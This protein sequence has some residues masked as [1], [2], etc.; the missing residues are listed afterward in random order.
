MKD[1]QPE[2]D[3]H[4]YGTASDEK[5]IGQLQLQSPTSSSIGGDH[6]TPPRQIAGISD[7]S[8]EAVEITPTAAPQGEPQSARQRENIGDEGDSVSGVAVALRGDFHVV[9]ANFGA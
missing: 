6:H 9:D 7:N 3:D 5:D 1:W 8:G 2:S 4:L